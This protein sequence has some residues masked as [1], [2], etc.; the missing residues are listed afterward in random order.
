MQEAEAKP[1][2]RDDIFREIE[3]D[4]IRVKQ[5]LTELEA[6][7]PEMDRITEILG[8]DVVLEEISKHP[9]DVVVSLH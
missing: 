1:Q 9:V 2:R 6:T 7:Q 4:H 5:V 3:Q 8:E